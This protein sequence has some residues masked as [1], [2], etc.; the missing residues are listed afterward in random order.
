MNRRPPKADDP[1]SPE[2]APA[3]ATAAPAAPRDTPPPARLELPAWGLAE[4]IL[5]SLGEAA[6]APPAPPGTAASAP[7]DPAAP[8]SAATAAGAAAAAHAPPRTP[9]RVYSFADALVRRDAA[10]R[11]EQ[12]QPQSWVIFELA[13][14]RFGLPV[15]AVQEI[16]RVAAITRVP[17]TPAPVRGITN[18][19][20]RVLAVVDLRVR[21]GM[22]AAPLGVRNRILVVDSRQRTLGLLVDAALQVVKLLPSHLEAAPADVVSTRSDY[23][24]GVYHLDEQLIIAL[25]LDRVLLVHE[26]PEDAS[27]TPVPEPDEPTVERPSLP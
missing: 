2:P 3:D 25:D 24:L 18:L 11:A 12:E 20:G 22:G 15:T 16:L 6:A 26:E 19:R 7:P 17:H 1:L 14:E 10:A 8:S 23:I 9:H 4:D 5:A 27:A 21:L 13:G